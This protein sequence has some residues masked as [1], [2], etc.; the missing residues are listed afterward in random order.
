[1]KE[2][3]GLDR[4]KFIQECNC[5]LPPSSSSAAADPEMASS[6]SCSVATSQ[7]AEPAIGKEIADW[8]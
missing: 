4:P 5:P 1:M 2:G 8:Y 7:G 3:C 6:N